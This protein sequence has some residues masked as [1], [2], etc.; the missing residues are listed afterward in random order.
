MPKVG[1]LFVSPK[2]KFPMSLISGLVTGI[3]GSRWAHVA[4][5]LKDGIF[6][7]VWPEVMVSPKD[8]YDKD[9]IKEVIWVDL[10][11]AQYAKLL[12]EAQRLL[13]L[14]IKYGVLD[15]LLTGLSAIFGYRMFKWLSFLYTPNTM[16]CSGVGAHLLRAA[17]QDI[18]GESHT[19][20]ISPQDLYSDLKLQ[21]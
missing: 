13:D 16:H 8:K 2:H 4:M 19:V 11:D 5:Y 15:G 10:T 6:E 20:Q 3:C 9:P 21:S 14:D 7:A 18:C 1:V 17:G 12:A